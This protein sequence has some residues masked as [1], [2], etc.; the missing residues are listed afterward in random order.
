MASNPV[1]GLEYHKDDFSMDG[2]RVG[3][4]ALGV[5]RFSTTLQNAQVGDMDMIIGSSGPYATDMA[6]GVQDR[7]DGQLQAGVLCQYGKQLLLAKLS[8]T[9]D[10]VR[11]QKTFQKRARLPGGYRARNYTDICLTQCA[12]N[13]L[14]VI[15]K[16]FYG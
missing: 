2:L 4:D 9:V 14:Y 16:C 1:L 8:L 5:M 13:C 11:H 15:Y 12:L 3:D 7:A 10:P 6:T